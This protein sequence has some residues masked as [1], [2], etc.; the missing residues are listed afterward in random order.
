M[1]GGCLD[2]DEVVNR[3]SIDRRPATEII[4]VFV[5]HEDLAGQRLAILARLH[6]AFRDPPGADDEYALRRL[7]CLDDQLALLEVGNIEMTV[8]QGL[9]SGIQ[10]TEGQVIHLERVRHD[11]RSALVIVPVRHS[12]RQVRPASPS[13]RQADA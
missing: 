5:M 6:I 13:C 10:Q 7:A 9:L 8:Q 3:H 4:L 2:R 1:A 11:K 12:Q